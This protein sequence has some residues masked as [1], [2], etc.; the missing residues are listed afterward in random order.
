MIKISFI[1][2]IAIFAINILYAQQQNVAMLNAKM[3]E[4]E[5]INK[6]FPNFN[7]LKGGIQSTNEVFKGKILYINFWFAACSP[8]MRE[9]EQLNELY[10]TFKEDSNFVFISIT[11]DAQEKIELVKSKFEI[12]YTIYSIPIFESFRLNKTHS[13][14]AN[15]IL[16]KNGIIRFYET[17]SR[18][19]DFLINRH[20]KNKVYPK[21]KKLLTNI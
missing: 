5:L 3:S 8:C 12:K 4:Q 10:N 18:A 7:L 2:F 17:G 1:L 19:N 20:F 11:Y 15:I 16:D 21:I 9:M 14:P 13:Y 6:P